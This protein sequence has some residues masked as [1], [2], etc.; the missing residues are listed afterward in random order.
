MTPARPGAHPWR[1]TRPR[2]AML[3]IIAA[4]VVLA[5]LALL[6][7]FVGS[8]AFRGTAVVPREPAPE[9]ALVDHDRQLFRLSALRGSPAVLFF[10]YTSC[11]DVCP[12]TLATMVRAARLLGEDSRRLRFLMVTVDPR[13][14]TPERLK[15]YLAGFD[16]S[17]VGL[18]GSGDDIGRIVAAYGASVKEGSS[19]ET[20]SSGSLRHSAVL[21]LIDR[22]GRL[23]VVFGYGVAADDLAAD[24]RRLLRE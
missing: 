22:S 21:Y 15:A 2:L 4:G 10:G 3:G 14:D 16:P 13:I 1:P 18:T 23:A 17:F 9:I 11:P 8:P 12:T 7:S 20:A 6:G 19:T 24:A 5:V